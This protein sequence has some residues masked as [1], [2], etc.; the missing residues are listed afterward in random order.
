MREGR[1]DDAISEFEKAIKLAPNTA[2]LHA[3]L[4]FAYYFSGRPGHA[5]QECQAALKLNPRL[6][7]VRDILGV[8]LAESG[9]C[10]EALEV[11][12]KS[13]PH[14]ADDHL[15]KIAGSD[16]VRCSMSLNRPDGAVDWIQHLQRE[17]PNDPQVLYLATHIYSDLSTAASQQLLNT[18]PGSLYA[19]LMNAEVMEL[20]GKSSDAIDEYR[21]VLSLDPRHAGAHYEI[22]RLLLAGAKGPQTR[23]EARKEFEE[24]L[25]I[26]PSNAGAEYQLGKMA[27]EDRQWAEAEKHYQRAHRLEPQSPVILLG[28]ANSFI[29]QGRSQEALEP[30]QEAVKL[31]PKAPQPHYL[32]SFVYRRLGRTEDAERELALYQRAH[33]E[34][35]ETQMKIRR[36]ITDS[37]VSTPP[38][39]GPDRP[40]GPHQ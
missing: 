31:I 16:A 2:E 12:D 24:E 6:T 38:E 26:A 40:Q 39:G 25:K 33:E 11:L 15:K 19:H 10:K 20:Q 13:F 7:R 27:F 37:P 18:A 36:G 29:S 14:I 21:K 32:L 9:Q 3:N 30:L 17:F 23:D 8:S 34:V 4:A 1:Y 5:A 35:Q 22:G 28:L